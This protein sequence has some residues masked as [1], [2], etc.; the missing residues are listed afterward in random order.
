[1]IWNPVALRR[2]G[3]AHRPQQF[4]GGVE[5]PDDAIAGVGNPDLIVRSRDRREDR[6]RAARSP[7][8]DALG[9]QI[10]DLD[11]PFQ[12]D[13]E[14]TRMNVLR[15][16]DCQTLGLALQRDLGKLLP[17]ARIMDHDLIAADII[18]PSPSTAKARS[19]CRS[20]SNVPAS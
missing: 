5:S 17:V 16:T 14:S 3:L 15:R 1:M 10:I 8:R 13:V 6:L 7:D 11:V 12:S 2:I 18:C 9:M 4:T 19:S 20:T